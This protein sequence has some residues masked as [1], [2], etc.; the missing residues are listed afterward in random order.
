MKK[1]Q[2]NYILIALVLAIWGMTVFRYF[3]QGEDDIPVL[4]TSSSGI[5]LDT[6]PSRDTFSL[7]NG[8]R[9]PFL[10]QPF[11]TARSQ[12]GQ[13]LDM[14][15]VSGQTQRSRAKGNTQQLGRVLKRD[16]RQVPKVSYQGAVQRSG[17]TQAMT[18]VL[19]INDKTYI[20]RPGDSI[21]GV[22]V[23]AM[24]WDYVQVGFADSS[25]NVRK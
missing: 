19:L 12:L 25:W 14:S 13:G 3:G 15:A 2:L 23:M 21:S 5:S 4:N 1:K 9:D 24:H 16:A 20:V 22:K 11:I 10:D 17:E 7:L 18:G 8:Y 6:L